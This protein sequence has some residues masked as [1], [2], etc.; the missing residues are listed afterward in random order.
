VLDPGTAV[1]TG[2]TVQVPACVVTL[3]GLA[4]TKPAGRVSVN[5]TPASA[6]VFVMV[7]VTVEVPFSPIAVGL[8]DLTITGVAWAITELTNDKAAHAAKAI[9]V[10]IFKMSSF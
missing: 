7:N 2:A 4:T 6:M 8:N 5:E 10:F 3:A 1:T 9:F